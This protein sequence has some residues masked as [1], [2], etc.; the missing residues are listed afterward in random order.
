MSSI[1]HLIAQIARLRLDDGDIV[2]VRCPEI[3]SA[4]TGERIRK[5]VEGTLREVGRTAPV[6]ILDRGMSVE[7]L[8][9]KAFRKMP[10]EQLV[11]SIE[12]MGEA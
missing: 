4:E 2:L 3:I 1:E 5:Y 12:D 6:M 9:A 10:L 7:I 8:A 11:T